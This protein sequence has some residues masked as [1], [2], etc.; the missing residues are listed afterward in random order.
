MHE[1]GGIVLDRGAVAYLATVP[2]NGPSAPVS[3]S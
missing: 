3:H 1:S 2:T